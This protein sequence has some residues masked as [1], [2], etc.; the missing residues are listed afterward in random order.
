APKTNGI[1]GKDHAAERGSLAAPGGKL[2][3]SSA[4]AELD[5][6]GWEREKVIITKKAKLGETVTRNTPYQ[7]SDMR[8]SARQSHQ[9]RTTRMKPNSLVPPAITLPAAGSRA[10]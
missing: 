4:E 9:L 3:R 6:E 8:S 2:K 1:H 7:E 5:D 10:A